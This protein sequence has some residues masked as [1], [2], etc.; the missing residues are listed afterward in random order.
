MLSDVVLGAIFTGM[1]GVLIA[2]V[3]RGNT[4]SKKAAETAAKAADN[5]NAIRAQ[6]ENHHSTN[7]R[8][9]A[10]ERHNENT[11]TLQAVL[12]TVTTLSGDVRGLRRDIGRSDQRH[13]QTDD[14]LRKVEHKLHERQS[15]GRPRRFL[16]FIR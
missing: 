4:R 8:V 6:V 12:K 7:L 11:E 14:R 5:T 3:Q 10:D 9:E 15:N 1:F 2:L 13:I 16:H